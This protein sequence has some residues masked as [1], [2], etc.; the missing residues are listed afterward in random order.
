VPALL[1]SWLPWCGIAVAVVS[2]TLAQ[3]AFGLA[4]LS[5]SL[6]AITLAEPVCGMA[7]SVGVLDESL[8]HRPLF[9]AAALAGL[10]VMLAGVGILTRSPLVVDPHGPRRLHLPAGAGPGRPASEGAA[11]ESA[12]SAGSGSA[13]GSSGRR[14][15]PGSLRS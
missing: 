8:P 3:R 7:L 6:P 12:G 9:L 15:S 13:A 11:A 14:W 10:V 1:A 4:D 5:A 2:L